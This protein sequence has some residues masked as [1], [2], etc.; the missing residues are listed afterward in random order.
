MDSYGGFVFMSRMVKENIK[1]QGMCLN[2]SQAT[3]L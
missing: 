3:R 1:L 2:P